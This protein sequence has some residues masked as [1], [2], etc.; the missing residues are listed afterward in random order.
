MFALGDNFLRQGHEVI[1]CI[2]PDFRSEA[3][4]RGFTYR[5]VGHC[6]RDYLA[7][8]SDA[9]V[10]GGHKLLNVTLRYI[11]NTVPVQFADLTQASESADY[12]FGAGVQLAAPSVAEFH[13][14][15]YRYIAYC[16]V[17]FPS[18]EHPPVLLP[19]PSLPAWINRGIGC[20]NS[21]FYDIC[22]RKI[23][24]ATA[25]AHLR[26]FLTQPGKKMG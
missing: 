26:G 10:H 12:I 4:Q 13:G 25:A 15:P 23:K 14:V 6:V 21:V 3:E 22:F 19:L 7:E 17:L 1:T 5:R 24:A 16:P 18:G 20:C 2:P 9:L 8:H 11:K